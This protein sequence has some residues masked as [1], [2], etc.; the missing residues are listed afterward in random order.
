MHGCIFI[1]LFYIITKFAIKYS[2]NDHEAF[3]PQRRN[4][5][6]ITLSNGN[7]GRPIYDISAENDNSDADNTNTNAIRHH[8]FHQQR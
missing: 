7:T 1:F 2:K 8:H 6:Q 4:G 3:R 5:H